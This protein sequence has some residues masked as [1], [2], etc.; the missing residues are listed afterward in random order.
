MKFINHGQQFLTIL[1][2]DEGDSGAWKH[3]AMVTTSVRTVYCFKITILTKLI[4]SSYSVCPM[5][6][7]FSSSRIM[8][9]IL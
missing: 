2:N 5:V 6:D 1:P 4:L 9:E 8:S 7:V 3:V